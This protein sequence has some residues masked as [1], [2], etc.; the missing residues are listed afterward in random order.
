MCPS[1]YIFEN[2]KCSGYTTI[3]A[4]KNYSCLNGSLKGTKCTGSAPDPDAVAYNYYCLFGTLTSNNRCHVIMPSYPV[5]SCSYDYEY[6]SDG[7]CHKYSNPLKDYYCIRGY[8][9]DTICYVNYSFDAVINY[10]CPSGY[11]LRGGKKMFFRNYQE[12]AFNIVYYNEVYELK[13]C[14]SKNINVNHRYKKGDT[15]LMVSVQKNHTEISRMLLA[16]GA[17]VNDENVYG[18]TPLLNIAYSA[19]IE[20]LKLLLQKGANVNEKNNTGATPLLYAC[21]FCRSFFIEYLIE[22]GTNVNERGEKG[23]TPLIVATYE[24]NLETIKVLLKNKANIS[25]CDNSGRTPLKIAEDNNDI[26]IINFF[27]N[28][29]YE[30]DLI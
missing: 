21:N 26:E 14:L 3:G 16:K 28:Y 29:Y 22:K 9:K 13:E 5:G 8:W 1:G 12:D 20:L 6:K 11:T 19:N 17:N 15:L 25:V 23:L 27:K 7:F 10:S 4:I 30:D 2:D 24:S 18:Y